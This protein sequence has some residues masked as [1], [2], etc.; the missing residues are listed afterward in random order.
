MLYTLSYTR[1]HRSKNNKIK[2]VISAYMCIHYR[3][4]SPLFTATRL[5]SSKQAATAMYQ[6]TR[7]AYILFYLHLREHVVQQHQPSGGRHDRE[8]AALAQAFGR[9]PE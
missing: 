5:G 9:L 8:R 2:N 4:P 1:S 6:G 7:P 3:N